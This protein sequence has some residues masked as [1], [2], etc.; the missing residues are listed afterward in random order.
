[1]R[2]PDESLTEQFAENLVESLR[3]EVQTLGQEVR[4]LGPAPAPISKL[5]GAFRF[6]VLLLCADSRA[7]LQIVE[8]VRATANPPEGVLWIPDVDP[9]DML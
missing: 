3:N 7:L 8:A 9:L 5:R 6:H 4:V 1:M 2:G